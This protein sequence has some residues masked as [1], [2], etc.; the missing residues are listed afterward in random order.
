VTKK[1]GR[2][3][4]FLPIL[5]GKKR[6]YRGGPIHRK[7]ERKGGGHFCLLFGKKN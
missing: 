6:G 1:E 5:V 4:R 3:S 2:L 7:K